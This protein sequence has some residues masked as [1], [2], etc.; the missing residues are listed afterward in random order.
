MAESASPRGS[1]PG[2]WHGIGA[3][4]YLGWWL[5]RLALTPLVFGLW[6][7]RVKGTETLPKDGPYLLLPNHT[8]LVDPIW[9]AARI[10]RPSHFMAASQLWRTPWV[11]KLIAFF[12]AFQKE[13]GARDRESMKRVAELYA[14]GQIV[15]IFVEGQRSWDGRLNPIGEG[16]GRLIQRLGARVVFAKVTTGHLHQPRWSTRMRWVPVEITYAPPVEYGPEWTPAAITADVVERL[17]ID[18]QPRL[19][20]LV[21][22]RFR[23]RGL[24]THLWGCPS[25][26]ELGGM[27]ARGRWENDVAC[28]HC[29]AR[30]SVDLESRLHGQEGAPDLTL[31]EARERLEAHLGH[32]P[33]HPGEAEGVVLSG[34]Q[35]AISRL[36]RGDAGPTLLAQGPLRLSPEALHV[37]DWSL[38]LRELRSAFMQVG[39]VL[40]LRTADQLL[41]LDTGSD[42][43]AMWLHFLLAWTEATSEAG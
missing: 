27:E 8:S 21:F 20:G 13:K 34:A 23:A 41:Q 32:P 36:V 6:R 39:A 9:V 38:D 10:G 33:Q 26:R 42:S 1:L 11:G 14:Q 43:T 24:P 5:T 29:G 28:R 22:G 4:R 37:G 40:Q 19:S 18:P 35:G 30:W 3:A 15:T 12:G 7:I 16:V 2:R 31:V 25:C 17:T